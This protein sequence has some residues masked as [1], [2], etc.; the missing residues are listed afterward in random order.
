MF[1][2]R[3]PCLSTLCNIKP[4][5]LHFHGVVVPSKRGI[6]TMRDRSKNR[7]PL[8]RGRNLSIEA[9]QTVQALKRAKTDSNLFEKVYE[10]K[11]KRLVKSDMIAVLRE[12]QRQNECQLALQKSVSTNN[13]GISAFIPLDITE[14]IDEMNENPPVSDIKLGYLTRSVSLDNL[15]SCSS[16]RASFGFNEKAK[17]TRTLV[18]EDVRKEYWYKPH[19][20][21]Y[22]DM[23]SML[24]SN[25][26]LEKAQQLFY[27]MKMEHNLEADTKSLNA[28]ISTLV[29]FG[30]MGLAMESFQLL[31]LVGCEPD[32]STFRF[33]ITGLESTGETSLSDNL[34][35]EAENY[36]GW[37]LEFIEEREEM[38][39]NSS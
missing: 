30:F 11:F 8:Q 12:L 19:V 33:L 35:L 7:K 18:F 21:V 26:L 17:D 14:E 24:A 22:S 2:S 39:L 23:I 25:G 29:E 6:I 37:P 34:R 9:I 5:L 28:L 4:K 15:A 20:L 32:E 1:A 38:T 13:V 27:C 10:S 36:F 16:V 31:K 3:A